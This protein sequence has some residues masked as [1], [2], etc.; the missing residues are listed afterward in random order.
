MRRGVLDVVRCPFTGAPL[1]L[2][3]ARGDADH[4]HAG[5][6]RSEA[7]A[8]PIVAGIP[9]L[10]LGQDELVE[11]V[12][13]GEDDRATRLAAFGDIPP[14]GPARVGTWLADTDRLRSV[15]RRVVARDRRRR[16]EAARA[17]TDPTTSTH[18]LFAL[19]YRDLHLRNPEV[20]AY[21]WYRFGVPR[22][23]A[24]LAC[25]EW[26]PAAGPVLDLGCG[27]G[28]LT[29]ALARH[30]DPAPVVGVDGLYFALYVAAHRLAPAADY[31]CCDLES[32]PL[33]DGAVT[34]VWASDVVH[35]LTH[36]ATVARELERVAAPASWGALIGLA[37]AGHDHEYRGRPLS[38]EGYCRLLPAG[39]TLVDDGQLVAGYL[40]RRAASTAVAAGPDAAT[41][42]ALWAAAEL[43][44]REGA[45]F[46]DWPHG[47]GTLVVNP[48]FAGD[49][50]LTRRFPTASYEREHGALTDYVPDEADVSPAVR[51]ALDAGDRTPEVDELV[52]RFVLLGTPPAYG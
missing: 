29:W 36:K 43:G 50:H 49:G 38:L 14:A 24:A 30:V 15:G 44:P 7:G 46:A 8:F 17:L 25:L 45:T 4:L 3:E 32:L 9:V 20:F 10:R 48:L 26:A 23:L 13:A 28:H 47:R 2:E 31:V 52:A 33:A 39:A 35:A 37:V 40:E 11:L 42:S 6:L 27:A 1:A 41:V 51:R 16:D 19:A 18:D 22:H 21:N 12:R 34:G 5:V